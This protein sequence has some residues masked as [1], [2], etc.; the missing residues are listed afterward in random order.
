MTFF[1]LKLFRTS[2]VIRILYA[3]QIYLQYFSKPL[4]FSME[5]LLGFKHQ[6]SIF[7]Y[8]E[9]FNLEP[10]LKVK[11]ASLSF[12]KIIN[13][14]HQKN[15]FPE[16]NLGILYWIGPNQIISLTVFRK[17]QKIRTNL[18]CPCCWFVAINTNRWSTNELWLCWLEELNRV[19]I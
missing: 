2:I 5:N 8:P 13:N 7:L 3:L 11:S 9:S 12:W 1:C 6:S 4:P 15:L 16:M 18:Q 19:S 10:T 17:R 14:L